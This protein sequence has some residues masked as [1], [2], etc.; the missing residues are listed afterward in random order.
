VLIP[1]F[2][3]PFWFLVHAASLRALLV[4]GRVPEH[5]DAG[6][7][8][9]APASRSQFSIGPTGPAWRSGR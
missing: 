6:P 3:V 4:P 2:L 9:A 7:R 5:S 8:G 1:A